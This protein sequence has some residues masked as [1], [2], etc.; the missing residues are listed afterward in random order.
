M[1][2]KTVPAFTRG[3]TVRENP[4][5]VFRWNADAIVGDDNV[6]K[7]F[8]RGGDGDDEFLVGA[9]NVVQSVLGVANQIDE[10]LQ[11]L[12]AVDADRWHGREPPFDLDAVALERADIH[13]NGVLHQP[14]SLE[15]LKNAADFG[16]ALLHRNYF[17]NVLDITA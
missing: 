13:G 4:S 3:E 7:T 17:L 9:L 14:I 12:M 1:E 11:Y 15:I 5:Q 16:V 8:V 6:D 2:A 10:N